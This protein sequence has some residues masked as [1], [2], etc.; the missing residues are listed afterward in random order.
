M[1]RD[2][3][4]ILSRFELEIMHVIWDRGEATIQEVKEA[5]SDVHPGAY[6]TFLTVMRRMD[7]KGILKH[8]IREEDRTYVYKPLVSREEV[9][10]SMFQDIYHRLF[11]GSSERLMDA[12]NALFRKEMIT[13]EE[14][15]RLRELIAEKGKQ[16]E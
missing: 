15:Q 6:S 10:T 5:L 11:L 8:E 13:P 4:T 1:K 3:R 16:D 14:I 7:E 9:S 12:I 2:K